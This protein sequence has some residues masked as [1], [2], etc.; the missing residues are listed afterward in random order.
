MLGETK[1]L[2]TKE[3]AEGEIKLLKSMLTDSQLDWFDD[4]VQT[5][6]IV[7]AE[8]VTY[9]ETIDVAS[10]MVYKESE[11]YPVGNAGFVLDGESMAFG[12]GIDTSTGFMTYV[13][14]KIFIGCHE[15]EKSAEYEMLFLQNVCD[16]WK[17]EQE[18]LEQHKMKK[19]ME[20]ND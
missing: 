20:S 8:V 2:T 15:S 19:K 1:R 11:D 13:A 7:G 6:A 12:Y 17:R 14:A 10:A 16:F 5:K 4:Q 18:L 9:G 3:E